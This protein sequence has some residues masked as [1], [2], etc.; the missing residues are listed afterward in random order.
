M[1]ATSSVSGLVSGLDTS[2]IISQLMQLEAQP[3][4]ALKTTLTNTQSAITAY[5]GL[6]TKFQALLTAAQSLES[7]NTWGARAATSSD[8]TV[9]ASAAAGA[10]S[11]SIT[12][13]VNQ[14]AA[15]HSLMTSASTGSLTDTSTFT[16]GGGSFQIVKGDGTTTTVTPNDGSLTT[17]VNAINSA[18]AGVRAAAVQVAPGQYKLQV[19][20][21]TTGDASSFTLQGLTG[22]G[23]TTV[24]QT[25]QNASIHV[26]SATAG[27]DVTSA[28]NT[29]IDVSPGL[30]FTVAK[31]E[32]TATVSVANDRD[33]I[34]TAVQAM[35][36]A[37]NAVLSEITKQ[38]AT[39]TVN[40]NGTRTGQGALA[41]D[42]SVKAMTTSII[43]AVTSALGGGVS[44]ARYGIQSTRDGTLTFDKSAF[45]AAY[46]ADPDGTRA[47]VAPTTGTGVAQRLA[48]VADRAT[49]PVS[50]TITT[51]IASRNSTIQSLNDQI[52]Q[53]DVRLAQRQETLQNQFSAMEVAL[54]KL[55][56]QASWLNGQI[57]SLQASQSASR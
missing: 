25:G 50:G 10:V 12:F 29:F 15:A 8:P 30:T 18:S 37:A 57:S 9:A 43:S 16:T 40:A 20:S 32:T 4:T 19:T 44:A 28:T 39:G 31:A 35:V 46:N 38:T 22:L 51:T 2:S 49:D 3:Q 33:S 14:L 5:Q 45:Q 55:Q 1:A 48:T 52:A 42:T 47:A 34:A 13:T 26:G 7:A 27:F 56:S 6:N 24:V 11:G 23:G 17:V 53:W 21:A 36:D 54:Q 41:G